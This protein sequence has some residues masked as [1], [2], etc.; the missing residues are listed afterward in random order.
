MSLLE[1]V[2]LPNVVEVVPSDDD[3]S[4]HLHLDNCASENTTTDRYTSGKRTFL[5]DILSLDSLTRCLKT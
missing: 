4:L 3:G 5:V 2:V 1:T